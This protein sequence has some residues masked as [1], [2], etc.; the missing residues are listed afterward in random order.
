MHVLHKPHMWAQ[1]RDRHTANLEEDQR[2]LHG[3]LSR[4]RTVL[5]LLCVPSVLDRGTSS[6]EAMVPRTSEAIKG[7][8]RRDAAWESNGN[9]MLLV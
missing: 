1:G 6:S 9:D 5:Q 4:R 3:I 8:G 7:A 2:I